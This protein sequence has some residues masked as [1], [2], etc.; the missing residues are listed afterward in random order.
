MHR[1]IRAALLLIA[2]AA[3]AAAI[4]ARLYMDRQTGGMGCLSPS[5]TT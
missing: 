5:H 1:R 4:V 3:A 2:A